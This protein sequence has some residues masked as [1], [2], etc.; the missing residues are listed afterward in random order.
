M[1]LPQFISGAGLLVLFTG[2]S[3][4]P[5]FKSGVE[6]VDLEPGRYILAVN[7]R[8][9]LGRSETTRQQVPIVITAAEQR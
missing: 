7:A 6:N 3:Q 5:T 4:P 2:A 8:A 9:S 1:T